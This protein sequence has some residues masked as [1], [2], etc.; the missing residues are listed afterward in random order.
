MS[1]MQDLRNGMSIQYDC[2]NLCGQPITAG[3]WVNGKMIKSYVKMTVYGRSETRK[4]H[5]DCI[6]KYTAVDNTNIFVSTKVRKNGVI[7][8]AKISVSA[9]NVS[10]LKAYLISAGYTYVRANQNGCTF[11][12]P[13]FSGFSSLSKMIFN[14]TKRIDGFTIRNVDMYNATTMTSAN[15]FMKFGKNTDYTI[16]GR[17]FNEGKTEK[18]V[19][20]LK[21]MN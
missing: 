11:L 9:N 15:V 5:V 10:E 20:F 7:N 8:F 1:V 14:A 13:R 2:C 6:R 3:K 12:S 17:L 4:V 21:E 19:D 16:A 18:L